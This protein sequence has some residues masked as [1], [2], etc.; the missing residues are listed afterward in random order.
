MYTLTIH[1]ELNGIDQFGM[2]MEG[3]TDFTPLFQAIRIK[4]FC[5]QE[6]FEALI[7]MCSIMLMNGDDSMMPV[8]SKRGC[9]EVIYDPRNVFGDA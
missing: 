9:I 8:M 7:D 5:H 3:D 2:I 4:P 1:Q 6:L